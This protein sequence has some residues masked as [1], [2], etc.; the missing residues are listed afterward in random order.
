VIEI[1][2]KQRDLGFPAFA[3]AEV[4]VRLP[5]R[6][7]LLNQIIARFAFANGPIGPVKTLSVRLLSQN[8]VSVTVGLDHFLLPKTVQIDGALSPTVDF[9][10][11]PRLLI[12]LAP[13]GIIGMVFKI[14]LGS[15]EDLKSFLT[16]S[17]DR[18]FVDLRKLML[19]SGIADLAP[20]VRSLR[21]AGETGVLLIETNLH[22]RET[23]I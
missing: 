14:I 1:L 7:G 20:L 5:L 11:D 6:E 8:R 16:V 10:S 23:T 21:F 12:L 17:G 13:S 22:V 18:I 3:G 9:A 19:N 15:R 4:T 2:H